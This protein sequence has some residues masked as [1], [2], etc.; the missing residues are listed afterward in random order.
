MNRRRL[1]RTAIFILLSGFASWGCRSQYCYDYRQVG[2]KEILGV[3]GDYYIL[4]PDSTTNCI[5]TYASDRIPIYNTDLHS[6]CVDSNLTQRVFTSKNILE[7]RQCREISNHYIE[8]IKAKG[9]DLKRGHFFHAREKRLCFSTKSEAGTYYVLVPFKRKRLFG[10][11][12]YA[13]EIPV[14]YIN[15][16]LIVVHNKP[17]NQ[18]NTAQ[19]MNHLLPLMDTSSATYWIDRCQQTIKV[20]EYG[21]GSWGRYLLN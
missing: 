3:S 4:T 9:V 12:S 6:L 13:Y 7:I 20:V 11:R 18:I 21:K 1:L 5:W 8:F 17:M 14:T 2:C 10:E 16:S 19:I 15:D